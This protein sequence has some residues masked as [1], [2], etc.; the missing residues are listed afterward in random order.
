[1]TTRSA[2]LLASALCFAPAA[3][4]QQDQIKLENI[5]ARTDEI[6]TRFAARINGSR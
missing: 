2:F 3:H 4:A 6:K 5:R 1:M